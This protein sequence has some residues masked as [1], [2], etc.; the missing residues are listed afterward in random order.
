M[1]TMRTNR[2]ALGFLA[3]VLMHASPAQAH[4]VPMHNGVTVGSVLGSVVLP[5]CATED[6]VNCVWDAHAQGNGQGTSFVALSDG[7]TV[8]ILSEDGSVQ[9]FSA[10]R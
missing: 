7:A 10:D 8:E 9:S 5:A 3:L 4:N 6:S 2:I 1:T